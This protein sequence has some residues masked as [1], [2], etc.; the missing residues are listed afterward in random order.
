M[1]YYKYVQI[2]YRSNK[3]DVKVLIAGS[4]CTVLT[5]SA[6]QI[7]CETGTYA[8]SAIKAPIQVIINNIGSAL[9]VKTISII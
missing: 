9:N 1:L 7:Q 4:E 3:N 8:L 2:F 6:S 5:S